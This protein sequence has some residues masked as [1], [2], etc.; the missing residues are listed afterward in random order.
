MK[1]ITIEAFLN[2]AFTKEL[3]KVG[4]GSDGS[5][6]SIASAWGMVGSFAELGTMID[7]SPNGYG[8]IPDFIED[9]LPHSDA[10]RAGDAVR[11]LSFVALDIPEGWNPFPEWADDH[12]LIAAE[13]ER[14]RA[15]VMI[16]GDRLAG[17]HVAA[18]VT[19]CALLNRGPDWRATRPRE[20]MVAD[21]DNNPRWFC[22][23]TSKD[24]FGRSYTIETDGFDRRTRKPRRGA[25]RKYQLASSIRGAILDRMEWQQWQSALMI[26]AA[27][28]TDLL[29]HEIMP[30]EPDLE[31]W[32]HEEKSIEIA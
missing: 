15:E 11:Q 5:L 30:F 3:C 13:V 27:D 18:L 22:Q 2:W 19:T 7:R 14:V 6:A 24:A 4:S 1:K 9:G 28:L 10:V 8:V 32:A 20:A 17:R 31:P 26:L 16:K 29:G 25:Y 23:K 12:G 21:K